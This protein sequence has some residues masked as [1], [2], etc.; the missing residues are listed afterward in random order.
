MVNTPW[1]RA[2]DI[3][4]LSRII[5]ATEILRRELDSQVTV[6]IDGSHLPHEIHLTKRAPRT[7]R[8]AE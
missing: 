8:F 6:W 1:G 2:R 3:S 5:E 7:V 4:N